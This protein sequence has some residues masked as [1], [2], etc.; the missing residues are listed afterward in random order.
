MLWPL[1]RLFTYPPAGTGVFLSV[2]YWFSAM[3]D[4]ILY[5]VQQINRL[6]GREVI[7]VEVG[8]LI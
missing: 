8:E 3:V 1:C 4:F 2:A 5:L 7:D 6:Y